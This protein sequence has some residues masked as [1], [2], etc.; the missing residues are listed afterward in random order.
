VAKSPKQKNGKKVKK[1]VKEALASKK[2]NSA[3]KK[4]KER[5]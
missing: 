1:A 4:K 3:E 2:P 5:S